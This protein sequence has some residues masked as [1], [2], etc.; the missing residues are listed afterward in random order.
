MTTY[1]DLTPYAYSPEVTGPVVNVGWLGEESRF[2]VG[3]PEP[4][5]AEALLALVRFHHVRVTRGWQQCRLCGPGA[6]YPVCEPDGD[7]E[8]VLGGAEVDVPGPGVVYA[9]PNLVYH[10]V[11]RHHYRPP[12][13]FVRAV[14]ARA[15]ASA[16]AWEETKR[17]LS[18]G[19]PLR[20]EIRGYH[21]TGLWFDLPD[22]PDVDAFIPNDLYGP[23]GVGENRE[24]VT[25]HVPVDAVVV[26]HSD[27]E[28]RVVLRV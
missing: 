1:E 28:R 16:G 27:R 23:D 13:G 20:G 5:F 7:G 19:T 9:A 12:A 4:G 2:E 24:H 6:A 10:Y 3:D 8:V 14:L 21:V 15:E 26:G 18:V 17:A 25:F 22:R 11:V